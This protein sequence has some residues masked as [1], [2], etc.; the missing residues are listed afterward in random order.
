MNKIKKVSI[1][2]WSDFK[3]NDKPKN[4]RHSKRS[5]FQYG[6][7]SNQHNYDATLPDYAYVSIPIWS[8]FKRL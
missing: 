8:D 2:I 7:I 5:L 1:P 4:K 6:L 3:Q